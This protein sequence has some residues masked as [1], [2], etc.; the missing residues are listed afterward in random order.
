MDHAAEVPVTL[1]EQGREKIESG[2]HSFCSL[3]FQATLRQWLKDPR[4]CLLNLLRGL[5]RVP[6]NWRARPYYWFKEKITSIVV[7]T[8]TGSPFR[9]VGRY[10]H[11]RTASSAAC[12]NSGCP[13]MTS[14]D[15]TLPD[16][17]MIA[18]RRTVPEMRVW[19]ANGG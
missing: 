1:Q 15:S 17:E 5:A 13:D 6:H 12:T 9:R 19:R 18:W 14:S 7:S 2:Y 16:L 10:L 11:W 4:E 3:S 8:S